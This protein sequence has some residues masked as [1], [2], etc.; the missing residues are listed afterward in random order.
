MQLTVA[1]SRETELPSNCL[2]AMRIICCIG[3]PL[4][5]MSHSARSP[6]LRRKLNRRSVVTGIQTDVAALR[7]TPGGTP[8]SSTLFRTMTRTSAP[9]LPIKPSSLLHSRAD[10][11]LTPEQKFSI[12]LR[13]N[14][15]KLRFPSRVTTV[16]KCGNW[17]FYFKNASTV[18]KC[19]NWSFYFKNASHA[20]QDMLQR[21]CAIKFMYL[22]SHALARQSMT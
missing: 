15:N 22:L 17:S 8:G 18:V 21:Y 19:G 14:F 13:A 16:V 9:M 11:A 1:R 2:L 4:L 3:P 10:D 12:I 5:R 20:V 7:T 6:S